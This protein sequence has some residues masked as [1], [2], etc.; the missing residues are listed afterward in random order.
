MCKRL[1]LLI[2]AMSSIASLGAQAAE[3]NTLVFHASG[4]AVYTQIKAEGEEFS[5]PLFQLKADIEFTDGNMD[6]IGLQGFVAVPMSDDEANGMTLEVT[7]QSG[8][9]ITLTNP[10]TEPGD[11]RVNIL[12]GYA[13]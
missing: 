10:D 5:P 8:L 4:Q 9:Y 2:S 13:S 6:G 12:L 3:D 7:Q 1:A 11:L